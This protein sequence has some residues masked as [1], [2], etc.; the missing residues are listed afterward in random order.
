MCVKDIIEFET[1]VPFQKPDIV[2][3]GVHNF[4]NGRIFENRSQE[5]TIK[6]AQRVE[7]V[8]PSTRIYLNQAEDFAKI[9]EG[10]ILC[11][12]TDDG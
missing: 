6:L 10:V 9:S 2:I 1:V 11:I 12:N 3:T 5:G 4:E 7:E 8:G